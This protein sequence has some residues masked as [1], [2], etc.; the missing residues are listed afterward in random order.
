MQRTVLLLHQGKKLICTSTIK[1]VTDIGCW[2][3]PSSTASEKG[4]HMCVG[5]AADVCP[6]KISSATQQGNSAALGTAALR[7]R[8]LRTGRY[9]TCPCASGVP[10]SLGLAVGLTTPLV[11]ST[12]ERTACTQ[13]QQQRGKLARFLVTFPSIAGSWGGALC[14]CTGIDAASAKQREHQQHQ[15]PRPGR[16]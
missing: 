15:R 13:E 6:K 1:H 11:V 16:T 12:C 3:P 14:W 2:Q 9:N 8:P 5:Y 7:G 4:H 10:P